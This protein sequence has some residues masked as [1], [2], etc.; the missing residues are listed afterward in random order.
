MLGLKNISA[1]VRLDISDDSSDENG[2]D[3][4]DY[5]GRDSSV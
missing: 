4:R 3:G 5:D 1:H 2:S